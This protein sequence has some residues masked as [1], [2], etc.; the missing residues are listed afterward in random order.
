MAKLMQ[1]EHV[2]RLKRIC[3]DYGATLAVHRD[4]GAHV[5]FDVGHFGGS[6]K[7]TVSKSSSD[8][9]ATK[10]SEAMLRR[11]LKHGAPPCHKIEP[12]VAVEKPIAEVK[13]IEPLNIEEPPMTDLAQMIAKQIEGQVQALVRERLTTVIGE[14][15]AMLEER[16]HAY[17]MVMDMDRKIAAKLREI[18]VADGAEVKVPSIPEPAP[19][20]VLAPTVKPLT[21]KEALV[22]CARENN[23]RLYTRALRKRLFDE[24]VIKYDDARGAK[25]ISN[26]LQSNK[27]LFKKVDGY[28]LW[29][30]INVEAPGDVVAKRDR[31]SCQ[32]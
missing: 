23:G 6:T 17:E 14:L 25:S 30:L 32:A 8:R 2:R 3:D 22:A 19:A 15:D 26:C 9:R 24:G 1:R 11:I 28:G 18:R 29:E 16:L 7:L 4:N 12:I 10:N 13:P 5:I 27:H 21:L 31:K 20:P